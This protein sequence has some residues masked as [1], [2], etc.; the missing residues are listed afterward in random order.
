MHINF[1]SPIDGGNFVSKFLTESIVQ[2]RYF[3]QD[4]QTWCYSTSWHGAVPCIRSRSLWP[5]F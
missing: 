3:M 4:H 1:V 5:T 2:S